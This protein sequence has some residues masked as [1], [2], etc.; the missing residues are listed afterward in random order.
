MYRFLYKVIPFSQKEK[1]EGDSGVFPKPGAF[2]KPPQT[3]YLK[4]KEKEITRALGVG[5]A[6]SKSWC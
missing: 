1:V 3:S 6:G 4:E 2:S 5:N